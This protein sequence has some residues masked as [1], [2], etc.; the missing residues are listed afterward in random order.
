MYGS[1]KYNAIYDRI[2]YLSWFLWFIAYRK[3][4]IILIK[5][6]L[7]KDKNH[8]YFKIFGTNAY[9]NY[10]QTCSND[11]LYK[12]TT[13]LRQPVLSQPKQ[14][15]VQLLLYKTTTCV[16]RPATTFFCLPNEK[17]L[18]A[19]KLYPAKKWKIIIWKQCIE[20][21]CRPDYIYS[22]ATL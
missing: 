3:N 13:R 7:N 22:I 5:S 2:R 15:P 12:T 19:T 8:Y 1:E 14:I 9:V 16:T 18:T 17:T 21:K 11:H 6:V 4:V 10:S 20:N